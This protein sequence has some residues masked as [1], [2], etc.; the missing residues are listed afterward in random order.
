MKKV[1]FSAALVAALGL[2]SCGGDKDYCEC[3]E[4]GLKVLGGEMTKEE[5]EDEAKGCEYIKDLSQEEQAEKAKDC[6]FSD[7]K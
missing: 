7:M 5:A 3:M 4:I 6:D 2:S 1:L